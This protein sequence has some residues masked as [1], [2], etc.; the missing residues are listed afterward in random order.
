MDIIHFFCI[1]V[2]VISRQGDKMKYWYAE[3]KNGNEYNELDGTK[4]NEIKDDVIALRLHIDEQ[5]VSLPPNMEKYHQ[6]KTAS[7]DFNGNNVTIE[8]R[9]IGFCL[10]NNIVRIRVDEKG[11]NV[12]V[13]VENK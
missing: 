1:I 5:I 11:G 4:W 13:E 7:S 6:A 10:G 9:Y 12:S 2:T 8:S 3:T